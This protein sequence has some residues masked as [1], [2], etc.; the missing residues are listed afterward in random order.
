ME[1]DAR[2]FIQE[3]EEKRGSKIRWKTYS[4][5]YANSDGVQ[6]EYGVFLYRAGDSFWFEDF[7][8]IPTFLGFPIK[9]KKDA[10]KYIKYEAS[11]PMEQVKD[12]KPSTATAERCCR[13]WNPNSPNSKR[14]ARVFPRSLDGDAS[15]GTVHFFE[16]MDASNSSPNSKQGEQ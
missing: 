3:L 15:D 9:Q 13:R 11:F 12:T 8:R 1:D 6:R 7:E 2:K 16:L 10:P 4:T 14:L 5:W